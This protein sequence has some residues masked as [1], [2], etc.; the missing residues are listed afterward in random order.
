M[1]YEWKS[2]SMF[3]SVMF[4]FFF[5]ECLYFLPFSIILWHHRLQ[6]QQ[7]QH[8]EHYVK[9]KRSFFLLTITIMLCWPSRQPLAMYASICK[10]A[11][12]PSLDY[13][14]I[15]IFLLYLRLLEALC[16]IFLISP[17]S[18]EVFQVDAS[19][20]SCCLW[21]YNALLHLLRLSFKEVKNCVK[22]WKTRTDRQ[23]REIF[24][25]SCSNLS[26]THLLALTFSLPPLL[27]W[28]MNSK[29]KQGI[30]TMSALSQYHEAIWKFVIWEVK[31]WKRKKSVL[32]GFPMA[33]QL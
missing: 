25:F 15:D 12:I 26:L 21:I 9:K 8:Q 24:Y 23:L 14:S 30:I 4:F 13:C 19:S 29:R 32:E 10:I 18:F 7:R 6:Q 22:Y 31:K 20:R 33:F 5:G 1:Y 3:L 16:T 28:K 27:K 17:S 11:K 2:V